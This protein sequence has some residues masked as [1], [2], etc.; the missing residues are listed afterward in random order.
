MR[1]SAKGVILS[2][3]WNKRLFHQPPATT[4]SCSA[5]MAHIEPSPLIQQGVG[6][7]LLLETAV[8]VCVRERERERKREKKADTAH[9]G[10]NLHLADSQ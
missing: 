4:A 2:I 7:N 9:T 5:S 10:A 3:M 6:A 1:G 8:D